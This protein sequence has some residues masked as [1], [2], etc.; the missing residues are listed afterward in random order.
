MTENNQNDLNANRALIQKIPS[1]II[2]AISTVDLELLQKSE[3][4]F[5]AP[6][7]QLDISVKLDPENHKKKEKEKE[8]TIGNYLIKRTLGQGTFGK[9]KLGIYLPNQEKVAIKILEKDRIVEQDEEIRVKREFDM[10]AQFNH[11]NVILVAEIFES[12]ESFYSVM[13]YCEGGE[14]FNYIVKNRRLCEEE[15]SFFYFQLINGL[16]YIHNLGIVHRDLKPENLLLTKDHLLKIID[17]GLSNYFKKGQTELLVTPCGSPCYASPEMVAGKKYDGFKIDIW[18]TGIILYAM[19][20]GYLPFE[21]KDNDILFKKI[22]ECKLSFPKFICDNGK[23]LIEKIL[24][25]DPDIRITIP[26]IKKHP[27]FLKGKEIFEQEF[28]ITLLNKENNNENEVENNEINNEII[29]DVNKNNNNDNNNNADEENLYEKNYLDTDYGGESC[30]I[31]HEILDSLQED[32]SILDINKTENPVENNN[33]NN[34]VN[35]TRNGKKNN[36]VRASNTV[37]K[38]K[39]QQPYYKEKEKISIKSNNLKN[40]N[41][42]LIVFDHNNINADVKEKKRNFSAAKRNMKNTAKNKT[43]KNLIAQKKKNTENLNNFNNFVKRLNNYNNVIRRQDNYTNV[44]KKKL[45]NKDLNNTD[46]KKEFRKNTIYNNNIIVNTNTNISKINTDKKNNTSKIKTIDTETKKKLVKKISKRA[47]DSVTKHYK[48]N[49]SIS[50]PTQNYLADLFTLNSNI[51]EIKKQLNNKNPLIKIKNNLAKKKPLIEIEAP[52]DNNNKHARVNNSAKVRTRTEHS[53]NKNKV[54]HRDQKHIKHNTNMN[55]IKKLSNNISINVNYDDPHID[56]RPSNVS[57]TK[58]N[59]LEN[60]YANQIHNIKTETNIEENNKDIN[61]HPINTLPN[62][63]KTTVSNTNKYHPNRIKMQSIHLEKNI[64]NDNITTKRQNNFYN[65]S[66]NYIK[67]L[68]KSGNIHNNQFK[69][70][71]NIDEA[72]NHI[73]NNSIM[74]KK[75]YANLK[76]NNICTSNKKKPNVTI[77]NTVINVNMFDSR[78][79]LLESLRKRHSQKKRGAT[80]EHSSE[81]RAKNS[82]GNNHI[83]DALKYLNNNIN[84]N[85]NSEKILSYTDSLNDGDK[86]IKGTKKNERASSKINKND[87]KNEHGNLYDKRHT[88]YNSMKL[89]GFYNFNIKKK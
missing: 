8:Y 16:E 55:K 41:K 87:K 26:E 35:T 72:I 38:R 73:N 50:K 32:S 6:L 48:N 11:P 89:D 88:K 59:K 53:K 21:D 37:E 33:N 31:K 47:G 40:K 4:T 51:N 57:K 45:G 58:K 27:F 62:Y 71:F 30:Q 20:C 78:L 2:D 23:D 1:K 24:V 64:K 68:N 13:E 85:I 79:L 84:V 74:D 15:A 83:G 43:N 61:Y 77:R 82:A 76:N 22:L 63:L 28:N 80:V 19:L 54:L 36:K 34:N 17:F 9:V 56:K 29:V 44:I 18:S 46:R 14:L 86:N 49:I 25:T 66:D 5:A 67:L 42:K 81:H 75:K 60:I 39:S 3:S 70:T 7:S 65:I 52:F 10:L 12:T 69:N